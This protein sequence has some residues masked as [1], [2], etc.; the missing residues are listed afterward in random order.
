MK[1]FYHFI[2]FNMFLYRGWIF[3]LPNRC[4]SLNAKLLRGHS[5]LSYY[6]PSCTDA[7]DLS[8]W[9]F[10]RL[11]IFGIFYVIIYENMGLSRFLRHGAQSQMIY[12]SCNSLK[13]FPDYLRLGRARMSV[14]CYVLPHFVMSNAS[15]HTCT[16]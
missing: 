13:K 6:R 9:L 14:C 8:C 12:F 10:M 5:N 3:S 4:D 11:I 16:L 15:S 2:Y 7:D 1:L